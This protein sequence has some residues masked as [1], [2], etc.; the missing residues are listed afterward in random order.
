MAQPQRFVL[1]HRFDLDEGAGPAHL[2]EHRLLA[3][4]LKGSLEHQ[5]LDEVRHHPVLTLGGHDDQPLGTRLG[6]LLGDQFDAGGVH[7]RQQFLGDGLGGRQ[8]AGAQTGRR[9]NGRAGHRYLLPCGH[10]NYPSGWRYGVMALA[11][12]QWNP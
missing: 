9:H 2:L 12:T 4:R 8:E 10:H 11:L 1:N 6:G 5:V 7:H 3:A